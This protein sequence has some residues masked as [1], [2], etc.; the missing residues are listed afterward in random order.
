MFLICKRHLYI[1]SLLLLKRS[2]ASDKEL[3]LREYI[4][5]SSSVDVMMFATA[6]PTPLN[7]PSERNVCMDDSSPSSIWQSDIL[8]SF[9]PSTVSYSPVRER[10]AFFGYEKT[11]PQHLTGR[12]FILAIKVLSPVF[13][14]LC[15]NLS[16]ITDIF[17]KSP[18]LIFQRFLFRGYRA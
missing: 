11:S 2:M 16:K 17:S 8:K 14:F 13:S 12:A 18:L 6:L 10:G 9:L 15:I 5:P 3:F 1:T 7:F 4:T